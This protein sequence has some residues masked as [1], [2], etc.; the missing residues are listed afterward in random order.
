MAILQ[1]KTC[2]IHF[3]ASALDEGYRTAD[4][5]KVKKSELSVG[6][7]RSRIDRKIKKAVGVFQQYD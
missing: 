4:A 1:K 5:M 3:I 7:V 6:M 2:I